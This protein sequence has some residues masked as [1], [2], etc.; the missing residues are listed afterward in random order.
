MVQLLG[1]A[2]AIAIVS[3]TACSETNSIDDDLTKLPADAADAT[4]QTEIGPQEDGAE[5]ADLTPQPDLALPGFCD[6]VADGAW[7]E[8]DDLVT[9]Q[10]GVEA[11]RITCPNGCFSVAAGLPGACQNVEA[12]FCDNKADGDWC[13]GDNLISCAGGLAATWVTCELGCLNTGPDEPDKCD[14]QSTGFCSGKSDGQWCDGK[15][16]VTCAGNLVATWV[17]CPDGCV[18][19]GAGAHYC[20]DPQPTGFCAGKAN[21]KWCNG[22]DLVTCTDDEIANQVD[23]ENGCQSM[24]SGVPDECKTSEEGFCVGKMNGDWCM[25]DDVVTCKNDA[26][27]NQVFCQYGCQSMPL[28]TA[29]K[30]KTGGDGNFCVAVPPEQSPSPPTE[31]CSYMDWKM[32]PDG[33]YLNSTFG[34]SND[35]TTWGNSTSCGYLQGH[36]DYHD[37][38]FDNQ[39]N[40]CLPGDYDLPYVQG[41][42]DYDYQTV[43]NVV[44]DNK[45]GDVPEPLYFYVADAQRL[46]CGTILRV[47]NPANGRCVVVYTEDGGPGA[48]YEMADKGGR[49]ILDCSPAIFKYL[50]LQQ[51]G[52][53]NSDLVYVEW[54]LEGDVP[55]HACTPCQSSPAKQ[56][57]ES[58]LPPWEVN[59]MMPYPCQ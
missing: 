5:P 28:G 10:G 41:H 11:V 38:I 6:Q 44:A 27:A 39:T 43:L 57:N 23:C 25:G 37:C 12:P 30:C 18:T 22:D 48:T 14:V 2:L 42:V 4:V 34:T 46:G 54:G 7:C 9:C 29:D 51:S 40:S 33:F 32:S 47:S 19:A 26:I 56:G 13:D 21:G 55:G 50:Q 58:M 1:R 20:D 52:W 24:P 53:A 49:R 45:N 8:G 35:G 59:H 17:T 3:L 31:K 36:Y 16:L 15:S